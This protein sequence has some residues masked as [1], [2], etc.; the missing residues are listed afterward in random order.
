[1]TEPV[2]APTELRR[3]Q[4]QYRQLQAEVARL[5]WIAQGSL[6]PNPPRAWRLTRKVQGK[7]VTLALSAGQAQAFAQAIANHRRLEELLQQMR[8]LSEVALLGSAPGVK[9]RPRPIRTKPPLT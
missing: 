7:T 5:G 1:M 4:Q 9:K 8:Q 2:L 6:L 3:L